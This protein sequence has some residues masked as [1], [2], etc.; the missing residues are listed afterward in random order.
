MF[1]WNKGGLGAKDGGLISGQ[2]YEWKPN[3]RTR[4]EYLS[5]T[6][7]IKIVPRKPTIL[8]EP[9]INLRELDEEDSTE[10]TPVAN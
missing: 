4:D 9:I 10:I 3:Q 2:P 7:S 1:K 8:Q 5:M 6:G